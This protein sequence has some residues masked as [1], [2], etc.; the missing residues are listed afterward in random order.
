MGGGG[1][2]FG[3]KT[4]AGGSLVYKSSSSTSRAETLSQNNQNQTKPNQ[5]M[6]RGQ[7][8]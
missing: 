1:A 7:R 5:I 2:C 3:D 4:G 6:H 8:M